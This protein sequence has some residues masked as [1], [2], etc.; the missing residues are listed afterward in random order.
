MKKKDTKLVYMLYE[1]Y[2]E[3]I[4]NVKPDLFAF[5]FHSLENKEDEFYLLKWLEY[6]N[7]HNI[8][9]SENAYTCWFSRMD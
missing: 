2:I 4:D 7:V 1:K 9:L 5:L 3:M 6:V 8:V